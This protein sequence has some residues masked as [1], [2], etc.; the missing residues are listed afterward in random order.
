MHIYVRCEHVGKIETY[1]RTVKDKCRFTYQEIQY[2]RMTKLMVR[3]LVEDV[4][5][6]R[7]AFSSKQVIS[8][9]LSL[10]TIVE[11]KPKL[12]LSKKMI[13]YGS[14][15]LAYTK[16][17]NGIQS[18]SVPAIALIILNSAGGHYF[19]SLHSGKWIHSY[20]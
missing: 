18:R 9:I 2:K 5:N 8:P 3:S 1:V 17:T 14:Y 13:S 12:D 16:T 7:H 15:S 20:Q 4:V 19:I 10:S 6:I 11:C